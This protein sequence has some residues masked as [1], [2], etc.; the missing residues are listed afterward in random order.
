ME[1][2]I[3]RNPDPP[4]PP[5]GDYGF[6]SKFTPHMFE[7]EWFDGAWGEPRIV[8]LHDIVLHP[9]AKV[10]HYGQEIFEGM[11]AYA[12]PD[13]GS[14]HMFRP[15]MNIKRFLRSCR[16]MCMPEVDAGLFMEA[17][18]RLIDLDR[19]WVPR[20][21]S[22]LYIRP[23]MISTQAGLGVKAS[24]RYLFY[25]IIGPVGSYFTGGINPLRLKVEETY[26]RSAPGGVGSAKTGGNYAAALLPIK[27]AQ[28]AGFDQ[29]VWLDARTMTTVEE[30][31]AMNICFVYDDKVLTAPLSDTILHG[32]TRDSVGVLCKDFGLNWT[33]APPVVADLCADADS[34]KLREAFACGTAAVVTPIGSMFFQGKDHK[35]GDGA[36]GPV[37][38]R[39][40]E[41]L[42]GI[43]TG[44]SAAHPE[45]IQVVPQ[46][47]TV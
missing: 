22:A 10:L 9:A 36:E 40:R 42:C 20:S 15:D 31:G 28:A 5:S 19:T 2:K 34:G 27:E 8:P 30:M 4:A 24:D 3:T 6:G 38:K 39:L 37:T 45:W 21:P 12:N 47:E 13:D 11:K 18:K 26:V 17:L 35:V 14:V 1:I 44:T 29:I 43:H 23:T 32:V 33:E 41:T 7:M 25:I 16:R 46:F